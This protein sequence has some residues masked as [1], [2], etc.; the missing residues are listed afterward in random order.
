MGISKTVVGDD[1]NTEKATCLVGNTTDVEDTTISKG[2]TKYTTRLMNWG[3]EMRG[4]FT[5]PCL[6][7]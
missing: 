3:V 5:P 2:L 7:L 6:A 1:S 4:R